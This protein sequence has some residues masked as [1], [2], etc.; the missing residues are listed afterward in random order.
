MFKQSSCVPC[1]GG[2]PPLKLNEIQN[3]LKLIHPDWEVLEEKKIIRDFNFTDYNSAISFTNSVADLAENQGHHPY[4]H[5]NYKTV[6]IIV[7]THKIDG[8]HENDFLI[9]RKIDELF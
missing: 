5:I 9:A 2:I 1:Q 8:L 3:Y 7:F 4:I 6:R